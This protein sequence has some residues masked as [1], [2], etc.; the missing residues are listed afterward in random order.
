MTGWSSG[1]LPSGREKDAVRRM[2]DASCEEEASAWEYEDDI[3]ME[4]EQQE[5]WWTLDEENLEI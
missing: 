4:G 1:A 3:L 2:S 5:T